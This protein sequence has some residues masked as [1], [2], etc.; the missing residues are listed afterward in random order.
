MQEVFSRLLS[1]AECIDIRLLVIG[2]LLP[3]IIDKPLGLLL[4]DNGR[5]FSHT[6]FFWLLLTAVALYYYLISRRSW[7]WLLSFGTFCHLVLD[8]IWLIP[9]ILAWPVFGFSFPRG[10]AAGWLS[11]IFGGL[12]TKPELYIPEL[13]GGVILIWFAVILIRQKRLFNSLRP[14]RS[15]D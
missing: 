4:F 7:P 9:K 2:A 6:L 5:I 3:D 1:L 11:S 13:V 12:V 8:Q 10:D 15:G 14:A